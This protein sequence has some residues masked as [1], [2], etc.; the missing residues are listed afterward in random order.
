MKRRLLV[1]LLAVLLAS[2]STGYAG[3]SPN[4][5]LTVSLGKRFNPEEIAA[6]VDPSLTP[7]GLQRLSE[8]SQSRAIGPSEMSW[9]GA[10]GYVQGSPSIYYEGAGSL[11]VLMFAD[12]SLKCIRISVTDMTQ[13]A[14]Q[15]VIPTISTVAAAL[16]KQYGSDFK[17]YSDLQCLHAL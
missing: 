6:V 7:L 12:R 4:R 11:S 2:V 1:T 8:K 17:H 5:V 14:E 16:S 9:Y 13:P 15:R 10:L 3:G